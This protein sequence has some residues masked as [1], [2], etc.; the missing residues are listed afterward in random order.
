MLWQCDGYPGNEPNSASVLRCNL[1][2]ARHDMDNCC[3]RDGVH[4]AKPG[5]CQVYTFLVSVCSSAPLSNSLLLSSWMWSI[6]SK[7][8]V[9]KSGS[10]DKMF[11]TK[12]NFFIALRSYFSELWLW[13]Q[14]SVLSVSSSEKNTRTFKKSNL[15]LSPVKEADTGTSHSRGEI[16]MPEWKRSIFSLG[17]LCILGDFHFSMWDHK[18]CFGWRNFFSSHFF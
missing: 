7:R 13:G 4:S 15:L 3:H 8:K 9:L 17:T 18:G 2:Q 10:I 5:M 6:K 11:A 16:G 12:H 14:N 1:A